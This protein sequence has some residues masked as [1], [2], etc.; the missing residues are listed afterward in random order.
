MR[1][2]VRFACGSILIA[3]ISLTGCNERTAL[4]AQQDTTTSQPALPTA[5]TPV[6]QNAPPPWNPIDALL[7]RI[8]SNAVSYATNFN[9]VIICTVKCADLNERRRL[10]DEVMAISGT[11]NGTIDPPTV[12]FPITDL[13]QLRRLRPALYDPAAEQGRN[14]DVVARLQQRKAMEEA[15]DRR[16]IQDARAQLQYNEA[17]MIGGPGEGFAVNKA[18][19]LFAERT[20]LNDLRARFIEKYG[21][22]P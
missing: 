8:G 22:E 12:S 5:P 9:G 19:I 4:E 3:A 6:V 21:Y 18:Q 7:L 20:R 2:L 13:S 17:N 15:T 1:L 16:E 10:R 14:Q 11:C